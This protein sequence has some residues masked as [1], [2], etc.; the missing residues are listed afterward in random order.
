MRNLIRQNKGIT[1]IALVITIIVLLIL[2]GIVVLALTG[3]N[4]ILSKAA[5]AKAAQAIGEAK[6]KC[7]LTVAEATEEYYKTAYVNQTPT[8]GDIN[9]TVVSALTAAVDDKT[10]AEGVTGDITGTTITL[11]YNETG[12]TATGTVENGVINWT[13]TNYA[14]TS[15][16]GSNG[17]SAG[18]QVLAK[19]VL[20]ANTQ[21]AES[22]FVKYTAKD[23]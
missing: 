7:A 9:D 11:T 21:T 1:L 10:V 16:N 8:G 4:G 13:E 17:S 6:D 15:G 23:R 3:E 18:V 19:D 20:I 2:V 14:G 22:T 12:A 5:E